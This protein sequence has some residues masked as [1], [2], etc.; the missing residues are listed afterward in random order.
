M[1]TTFPSDPVPSLRLIWREGVNLYVQRFAVSD[2]DWKT[3]LR[4]LVSSSTV[5]VKLLYDRP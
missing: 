4:V 2:P 5:Q 3:A 1:T